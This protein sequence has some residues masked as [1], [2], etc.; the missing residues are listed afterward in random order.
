[1]CNVV[2][3]RFSF[4]MSKINNVRPKKANFVFLGGKKKITLVE[5]LIP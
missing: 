1:M 2:P 5:D 4:K 3:N